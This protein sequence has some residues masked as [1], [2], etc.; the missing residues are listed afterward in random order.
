[1]NS[2]FELW[3]FFLLTFAAAGALTGFIRA[4]ALWKNILD[5]PGSRSSHAIPTPRG[6]GLAIVVVFVAILIVLKVMHIIHTGL[7]ISI[8]GSSIPIATIG[9]WDDYKNVRPLIRLPVHFLAAIWI[10]LWS[11][12]IGELTFGKYHVNL[13]WFGIVLTVLALMWLLNLYN[14]MDGIDGLASIETIT[15]AVGAAALLFGN[16]DVSSTIVLIFLACA[17]AGFLLWN[18]HP[19]KIFL[20]DAGSGFLGICIGALCVHTLNEGSLS[21]WVWIILLAVFLVDATV[22]LIRRLLRGQRIYQA[23]RDH[24]YQHAARACGSHATVT[25]SVLLINVLWLW[26]LAYIAN[27]H[28]ILAMPLCVLAL[29]PLVLISLHWRAGLSESD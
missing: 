19:A 6:G 7:F 17:T 14:F 29:A 21:V 10:I 3:L 11:G 24:A 5:I 8:F 2:E 9:M 16:L 12:Y 18:W 26:P 13:D 20:G 22:T 27:R 15:V 28:Q 4:Y 25:V 1:M 23:H